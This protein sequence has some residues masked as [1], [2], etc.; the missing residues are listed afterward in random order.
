[1]SISQANITDLRLNNTYCGIVS[2]VIDQ[3]DTTTLFT[4]YVTWYQNTVSEAELTLQG[5]LDSYQD[6][7]STWFQSMRDILDTETATNLLG[8]IQDNAADILV[9]TSSIAAVNTALLNH[10]RILMMGRF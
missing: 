4:Q 8:L 7:F 9:H 1:V 2:G 10:K 5:Y 6:S 3:V